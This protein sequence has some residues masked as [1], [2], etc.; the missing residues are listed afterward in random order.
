MTKADRAKMKALEDSH[1][2]LMHRLNDTKQ[3]W[4]NASVLAVRSKDVANWISKQVE[5][6]EAELQTSFDTIQEIRRSINAKDALK[7]ND[8]RQRIQV[9]MHGGMLRSLTKQLR[10]LGGDV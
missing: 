1:K 2:K 4:Q 8:L 10:D 3:Q 9:E 6:Q 5:T 7:R